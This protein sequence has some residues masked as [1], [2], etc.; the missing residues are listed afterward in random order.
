[1]PSEEKAPVPLPMSGTCGFLIRGFQVLGFLGVKS[2]TKLVSALFFEFAN[3]NILKVFKKI[4]RKIPG[5]DDSR[6]LMV[7]SMQLGRLRT[8]TSR[9]RVQASTPSKAVSSTELTISDLDWHRQR[10]LRDK[11]AISAGIVFDGTVD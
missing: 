8:W 3:S 10:I 11:T 9:P 5:Y 6:V 7:L 2:K 1:M 4:K